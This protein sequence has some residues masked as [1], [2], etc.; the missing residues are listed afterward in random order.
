MRIFLFLILVSFK[1]Y[2]QDHFLGTWNGVLDI[3]GY[4][5]KLVLHI[6]KPLTWEASLDSPDQNA[7]N[8]KAEST[9]IKKNKIELEFNTIRAK[10]KG[11]IKD[12]TI[13]GIFIQ[14]GMN[15]KLELTKNIHESIF[16]NNR[17]QTPSPPY[18][19]NVKE[20]EFINGKSILSGSLT[21]PKDTIST[22]PAVILI[23]GSGP[24]DRNEEILGHKPFL[25]IADFLTR[26][27][28]A[29]LRYDDRGTFNSTG[30]DFQ[31]ATSKELMQDAEKGFEFLLNYPRIDKNRVSVLG[32]SE[33]G[34]LAV[35]L[36]A[37]RNDIHSIITLAGPGIKGDS[38]LALQQKLIGE[39]EGMSKKDIK[40]LNKLNKNLFQ[41]VCTIDN[42][43][44]RSLFLENHLKKYSK[45][46]TKKELASYGSKE[47]FIKQLSATYNSPWMLYF[48]KYNPVADLKEVQCKMLAINGSKDLQVPALENLG[49]IK[50]NVPNTHQKNRYIELENLNHLLQESQTGKIS[51]YG[52][53]TQTISPKVLEILK[54]WLLSD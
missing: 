41:G 4:K 39:S 46:L 53:L 50:T 48:L 18:P 42:E 38:L 26:H 35:M 29:V 1:G 44:E 27:G 11:K 31:D 16:M 51:E 19:Y 20:V 34:M 3:Q 32:H 24:Q 7:F 5:L 33:G 12:S 30:V 22:F 36:A 6:S 37:R 8:I 25:V 14:S 43:N 15:L 9:K 47:N 40:S 49:S 2:S 17:P 23:S 45:R 13:E 28:I 21:L 10:F 54:E 52:A